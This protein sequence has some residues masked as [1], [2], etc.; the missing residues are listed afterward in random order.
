MLVAGAVLTAAVGYLAYAGVRSG[1]SYY[2]P[3]DSFVADAEHQMRR[4]RLHGTVSQDGLT[5][6]A[7]Q[8]AASFRLLGQTRQ[9]PVR[10]EGTI[11]D[12]FRPGC[13]IVVEGRLGPDGIFQADRLLTKCASKYQQRTGRP[14]RRM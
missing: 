4:A 5:I 10:Y 3:V 11:P 1:N 6:D 13:E 14:G 8:G 9:L 7:G 2:L 12:L